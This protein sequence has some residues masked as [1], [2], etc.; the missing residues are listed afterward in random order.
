MGVGIGPRPGR[1]GTAQRRRPVG[2]TSGTTAAGPSDPMLH[3]LRAVAADPRVARAEEAVREA[4]AQLRWHVALRRRWREARSESG[5]RCAVASGTMEGALVPTTVLREA[6]AGRALTGAATGDPSLDAVAGL[7]RAGARLE[8]LMP[9]L[10][11]RGRPEPPSPRALLAG[12]HRDVAGPLA[13]AGRL[14]L[15]E[16]GTPRG[17]GDLPREGGPDD[18]PTGRALDERLAGI[19][20]LLDLGGAPALVRAAVV[21]A[22]MVAVR[23]FTAAN[24]AVGRL[25]VRHLVVRDGLEPTGTAVIDR[26]P[27]RA[28][29]AYRDAA[30]AYATG[31]PDGVVDW[32]V[33][34]AEALLTGIDEAQEVCRSVQAGVPTGA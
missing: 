18:A 21:H 8:S 32:V 14:P 6:V 31:T 17:P 3:A 22:E 2:Q 7:W 12:L 4:S 24:A 29:G 11:G 5:I 30:A 9:D 19:L 33:W 34:Q 16:V 26:Y 28:P 25:L 1:A 27:A 13:V 10:V 23:P 15:G 20:T